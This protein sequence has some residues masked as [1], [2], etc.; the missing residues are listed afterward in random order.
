[1]RC[2]M[3]ER[4]KHDAVHT[5]VTFGAVETR[6]AVTGSRHWVAEL[7]CLGALTDPVTVLSECSWKTS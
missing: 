1:M 2:V 5:L 4:Y 3:S 6:S 7:V